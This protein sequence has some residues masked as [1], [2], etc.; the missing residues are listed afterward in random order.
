MPAIV[1]HRL[2][3]INALDAAMA[4]DIDPTYTIEVALAKS[5]RKKVKAG[6]IAIFKAQEIQLPDPGSTIDPRAMQEAQRAA[7][8]QT[9]ALDRDPVY[10]VETEGRWIS[11]ALDQVIALYDSLG[12]NA[13]VILKAPQ[14][15]I[16][17]VVS[18]KRIAAQRSN[19]R[20]LFSVAWDID[21]L[22]DKDFRYD[23]WK[24]VIRRG[25]ISA[26]MAKR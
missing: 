1:G 21:R 17:Q 2:Q 3:L 23:P 12:G 19:L 25:K 16:R 4:D 18:S 6:A 20:E 10:F 13:R 26:A 15:K 11:W 14:L 8:K 24:K 9:E 7:N 5:P 22:L